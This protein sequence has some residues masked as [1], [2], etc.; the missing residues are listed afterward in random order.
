MRIELL[1]KAQPLPIS[2]INHLREFLETVIAGDVQCFGVCYVTRD[3]KVTATH[4]EGDNQYK[5]PNAVDFLSIRI[6]GG[7]HD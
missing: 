3:G 5:L 7:L 2:A 4:F 1:K 6:K